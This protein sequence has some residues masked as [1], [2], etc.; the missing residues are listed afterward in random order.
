M[1]DV[2]LAY[3]EAKREGVLTFPNGRTLTIANV[4][5]DQAQK[6]L[7]RNAAEFQRR[8]CILTTDDGTIARRDQP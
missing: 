5:R 6:F 4:S 7:E 3:D 2:T 1:T 8:D